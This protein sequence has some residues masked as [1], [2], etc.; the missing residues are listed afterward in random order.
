MF[1]AIADAWRSIK[2][3]FGSQPEPLQIKEMG[4]TFDAVNVDWYT[5]NG[6]PGIRAALG[7]GMPGWSGEPV[8]LSSA[9]NHSVVW[10]CQRII[11][12]S[13]GFLPLHM[14]QETAKGKYPALD[15]PMYSGLYNAPNE[16][17]TAMEFRETLTGHCVMQGN[18]YAQIARRSGSGVAME[19]YPIQP[20]QVIKID[21][22]AQKRLVYH[23]KE[24]NSPEKTYTIERG[25]PQD[26]LHI[27]GLGGDGIMGYSVISMARQSIGTS[28]SA[29]K[30]AAK[31]YANGGRVPYVL[32]MAQKFKSDADFE[33][34]R[35]DWERTYSEPHKAPILEGGMDYKQ[36]GMSSADAQFLQT[37]QFNIPEICRWF[38]VSPHLVGDLSRATFSNIEQ[39]ALEFV[40]MTLMAW[41]KRWEQDLWRCLL[42][43]EEK[44]QGYY[45]R[46]NVNELLRGDF[47]SRMQGYASAL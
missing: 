5:R 10:A 3:G 16:E 18:A 22:D 13:V 27:R 9:L 6:L 36:I 15:K 2:S 25:K 12:E 14:M 40:K 4:V 29:E 35:A 32:T 38:L 41:L 37:R 42:T 45:F 43:P 39:L 44:G 23:I 34:F 24:G 47:A 30:Y 1:P 8:S 33:K 20:S 7:S 19:L 21:R 31:F 28:L 46:H 11:S 26:I 17:M